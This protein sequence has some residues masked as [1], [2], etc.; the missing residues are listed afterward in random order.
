TPLPGHILAQLPRLK[1][2]VSTGMRNAAIDMKAAEEKGITVTFTGYNLHA[3]PELTWALL[4][5]LSKQITGESASLRNG[6]WQQGVG[7]DLHGK[8]LGVV[9]LGNI[10]KDIT[11]YA[12][13]FGMEVV[14]WSQ[15][16]TEE[17]ARTEGATLVSK[18]ELF[19]VSDFISVHLVLSARSR[20]IIGA[21]ELQLMKPTA[22]FINT[23]RGPLVDEAALV[24]ILTEQKIAGAALDVFDREPLPPD[25]PFRTLKNVL[26][27]PHIGYVTE[28]TYR[29]FFEDTVQALETWLSIK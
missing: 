19:R 23:S 26:A 27:T 1:R 3:A 28:N 13:A 18:E 9:G 17:K 25:H 21:P 8:T 11:R 20:G 2:I 5:A 24:S 10:G 4:M 7:A 6:G 12:K 29:T 16:L 15:H 14:A 22:Y